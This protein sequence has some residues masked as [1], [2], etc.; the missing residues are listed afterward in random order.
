MQSYQYWGRVL[1]P[2]DLTYGQFGENFTIEGLA[3]DEVRVDRYR[4]GNAIFEVK[5]AARNPTQMSFS[6]FRQLFRRIA[7]GLSWQP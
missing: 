1:G 3:D 6:I 4:I 5:F 7:M 2:N